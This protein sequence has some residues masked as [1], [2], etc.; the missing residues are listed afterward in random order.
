M[1]EMFHDFDLNNNGLNGSTQERRGYMI[2]EKRGG[3]RMERM[4]EGKEGE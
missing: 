3:R 2:R 4:R 1:Y